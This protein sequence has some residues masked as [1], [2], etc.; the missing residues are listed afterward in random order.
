VD[1]L[2]L[3]NQ[4][5]DALPYFI[6]EIESDRPIPVRFALL[7][8]ADE[9]ELRGEGWAGAIFTEVWSGYAPIEQALKLI[10]VAGTDKRIQ[11]LVRI[12]T[13]L[14][15]SQFLTK[16]LLEVAPFNRY[17]SQPRIYRGV[18]RVLIARL[19]AESYRQG[20]QG[21][22]RVHARPGSE[23]FYRALGFRTKLPPIFMLDTESAERLLNEVLLETLED[24]NV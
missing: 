2:S 4:N 1:F 19:I 5:S 10:S 11:G 12:G 14:P 3:I 6:T 18:G 8:A 15:G 24:D 16:S 17:D 7:T 20:T 21:R 9:T 23:S 13:V 22:I